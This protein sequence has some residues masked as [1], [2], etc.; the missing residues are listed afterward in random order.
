MALHCAAA[1]APFSMQFFT[2]QALGTT[3]AQAPFALHSAQ[4]MG[5]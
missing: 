4:A 1:L 3:L 2:W 5:V